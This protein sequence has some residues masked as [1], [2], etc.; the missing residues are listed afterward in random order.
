MKLQT[1]F[2][3][4][5]AAVAALAAVCL[6]L[7]A[8]SLVDRHPLMANE[9]REFVKA[10]VVEVIEDNQQSGGVY[11]GDQTVELELLS[12][13][14]S[15][16]H[17]VA[18]SS[19]AYLYGT[20]CTPNLKVVA[21]VS[22]SDGELVGSVY[23]FYREPAL[24]GM[25]ALFLLTIVLIGGR[26][27]LYSALGLVFTFLCIF[28]FFLPMVYRGY[29]PVLAA[30]V[31]VVAT[32]LVTMYL[33]GGFTV[34]A[35][36][37]VL[38]TVLGVLVAGLLAYLFGALARVSGYNVSDIESLIY[39]QEQLD[40]QVGQ[41]LFAGILIAALGA[42]MDVSMSIAST[43]QELHDKN[44]QLDARQLFR[45]GITVGH[46]MMGTMSNTLILAF[47]GGSIN[48]I[49]LFYAYGYSR[50]QIV[51]MYDIAIEISQGV[52]A[53]MGV[54]LTVPFVSLIGAQMIVRAARKN[55][56]EN[57]KTL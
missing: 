34:K 14:H 39:I 36:A 47:T 35:T 48:T 41:L 29:S 15:G 32:T 44:P 11:I 28:W 12:G 57:G 42:V 43:L 51:N 22:E 8:V 19:S 21:I 46:D 26:R 9:G 3:R 24:L 18:K 37:S 55:R 4:R 25:I 13:A 56:A 5:L 33:V 49:V 31:V 53:S 17:V 10:R 40:I 2:W 7:Y 50:M 6:G 23:G 45:S 54:V 27:G 38:G 52:S 16:A 1:G 20:H 30:I